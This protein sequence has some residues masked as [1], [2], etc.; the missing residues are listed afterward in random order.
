MSDIVLS[1][2]RAT[3]RMHFGN[4]VGAVQNF[5]KFQDGDNTCLYFVADYHTQTTI[6]NPDE[7]RGNLVEMVKD[8]IAAGLDPE[9]SIIYVQSS[10][11]EI[12]ELCWY[13]S[14]STKLGELQTIP[15]FKDLVK[16]FPDK[17]SLGLLTYPVLMAADILAPKATLVPVGSDQV[18]NVELARDIAKRFNR[19]Y[20]DT[21]ALPEMMEEMVKVVGFDGEKMGKSDSDNAIGMDESIESIRSRYKKLGKTDENKVRLGDPGTPSACLSVYPNFEILAESGTQLQTI[22]K[23]CRSGKRGCADCKNELVDSIAT[24]LVPF[25]E[26]RAEI[27]NQDDY[28][29][30]VLIDGG[31]KARAMIAVTLEEVR[32]KMGIIRY[33]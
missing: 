4:F 18:P 16:K 15:T 6:S 1:G 25:Q 29:K 3:G 5:V 26:K 31:K 19:V 27:A 20:G 28:V 21:F 9:K 24:T 32:E 12:T 22:A 2:I 33:V 13:L 30:D 8:Y 7:L 10:I 17:V 11:P 14:M 23:T